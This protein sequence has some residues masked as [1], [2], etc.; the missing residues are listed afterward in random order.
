LKL[1]KFHIEQ[2]TEKRKIEVICLLMN[3]CMT[4]EGAAEVDG[5]S[6]KCCVVGIK[7]GLGN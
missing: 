1:K 6:V 3:Y 2:V 7:E 4:V 5:L